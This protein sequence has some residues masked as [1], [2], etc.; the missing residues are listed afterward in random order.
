MGDG[1]DTERMGTDCEEHRG[2]AGWYV[3]HPTRFE[4]RDCLPQAPKSQEISCDGLSFSNVVT[5]LSC[6]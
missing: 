5:P 3:R 2:D 4:E 1:P 6:I